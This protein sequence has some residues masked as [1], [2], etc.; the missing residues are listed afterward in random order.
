M[1]QVVYE[2]STV[3]AA[4]TSEPVEV[5]YSQHASGQKAD[6]DSDD[7]EKEG[8][9]IVAY[10]AAI[11]NSSHLAAGIYLGRGEAA[12][13]FGCD[14]ASPPHRRV[15]VQAVPV[16]QDGALLPWLQFE[17]R[18]GQREAWEFNG[19]TGPNMKSAWDEPITWQE[20]LRDTAVALPSE[21]TIGPNALNG[22][23]DAVAFFSTLLA[24]VMHYWQWVFAG[25]ALFVLGSVVLTSS[26]TDFR[27][28]VLEPLRERRKFGQILTSSLRIYRR[29]WGL[30]LSLGA[31]FIPLMLVGS[32]VRQLLYALPSVEPSVDLA[33]SD[34]IARLIVVL[35]GGSIETAIG[36][37]LVLGCVISALRAIDEHGDASV[38]GMFRIVTPRA[39]TLVRA[40]AL[41]LLIIGGAA[42]TVVGLPYAV[43]RAAAW[44]FVEEAVVFDGK[45]VRGSLARSSQLVQGSWWRAWAIS[46]FLVGFGF[47]I[48][49]LVAMVPLFLT[50]VP[51]AWVNLTSSAIYVVV[52]PFVAVAITLLYFDLRVKKEEEEAGN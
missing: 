5:G 4:L 47:L 3:A 45:E 35:I 52:M 1:V 25:A 42:L 27:P 41:S 50:D 51:L 8:S 28:A 22:F 19:P 9:R 39:W 24:P 2:A 48:G 17:G 34:A 6:W 16:E 7:F 33:G 12:A 29:Y 31:L 43:N 15:D 40:R 13:G 49:P 11:G 30:M 37:A 21:D 44:T 46:L 10:P 26:R 18:W 38:E 36:Y 32:L 20:G 23:C 14:D